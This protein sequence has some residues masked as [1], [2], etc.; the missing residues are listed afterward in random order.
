MGA[1]P[2]D[3]FVQLEGYF[4]G[5]RNCHELGENYHKMCGKIEVQSR[6]EAI[7]HARALNLLYR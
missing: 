1:G 5:Y 2:F 3:L 6:T 4:R 7:A